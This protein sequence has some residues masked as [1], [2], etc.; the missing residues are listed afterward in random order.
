MTVAV[1]RIYFGPSRAYIVWAFSSSV[2]S[3]DLPVWPISFIPRLLVSA[4]FKIGR[5]ITLLNGLMLNYRSKLHT[6]DNVTERVARNLGLEDPSKIRLIPHNSYS[7]LFFSEYISDIQ[8]Y[9]VLDTPLPELQCL[10][11]LKFTFHHATKDEVF[12]HNVRLPNQSTI[13]DVLSEI[14]T[15]VDLVGT[16]IYG[17]VQLAFLQISYYMHRFGGALRALH[18]RPLN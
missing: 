16:S 15:K 3:L 17:V 6:Y 7:F 4:G 18:F 2:S 13:G 9:E 11:T 14:K 1:G 12:I 8:Y 10:K 5:L